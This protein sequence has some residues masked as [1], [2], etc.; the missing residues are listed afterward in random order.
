MLRA[1]AIVLY[2][3]IL[4]VLRLNPLPGPSRMR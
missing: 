1:F 4:L 2:W 3:T